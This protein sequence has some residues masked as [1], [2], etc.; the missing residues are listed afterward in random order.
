MTAIEES[1]RQQFGIRLAREVVLL[2]Q[3]MQ[4]EADSV[5]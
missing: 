3:D 1:V 2:P 5:K 4:S